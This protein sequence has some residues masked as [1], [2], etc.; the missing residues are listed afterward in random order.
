VFELDH[1]E[2]GAKTGDTLSLR[3]PD[4]KTLHVGARAGQ[5][6]ISLLPGLWWLW[7]ISMFPGV[8]RLA[9]LILRQRVGGEQRQK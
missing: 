3:S 5:E 9:T 8:G 6:L 4:G 2:T 7:P 1:A